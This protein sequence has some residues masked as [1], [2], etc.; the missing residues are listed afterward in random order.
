MTLADE[1]YKAMRQDVYEEALKIGYKATFFLQML[2]KKGGLETA[3][4]LLGP[5][6]VQYGFT[7]L[8]KR[9][10]LDLTMEHLVIQERWSGLFTSDQVAVARDRLSEYS[11]ASE[12]NRSIRY[13]Q[14]RREELSIA[15]LLNSSIKG[16]GHE[17][18]GASEASQR[19][20]REGGNPGRAWL[21]ETILYLHHGKQT[22]RYAVHRRNI[23][24][25]AKGLAAQTGSS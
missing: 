6:S 17:I 3:I 22:Q 13:T 23:K 11:S 24:P 19:H 21:G 12:R 14:L 2:A 25:G 8:W 7:E 4:S 16:L 1:F 15:T 18:V 20:S 9:G 10:R 5:A